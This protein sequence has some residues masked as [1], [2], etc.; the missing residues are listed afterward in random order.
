MMHWK[1][2]LPAVVVGIVA[3]VGGCGVGGEEAEGDRAVSSTTV[4][5]ADFATAR[6]SV[7]GMTCG[8]CVLATEMAIKRVEGVRSVNA[9]YDEEEGAGSATVEYDVERTDTEAIAAAV[10][11]A[12]FTPTLEEVLPQVPGR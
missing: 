8:G 7:D 6:F 3:V 12:G 10:R 4:E 5:N 9:T 11:R 2:M 1:G